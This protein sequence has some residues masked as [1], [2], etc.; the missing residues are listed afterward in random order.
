MLDT[1]MIEVTEISE[2]PTPACDNRDTRRV[3]SRQLLPVVSHRRV[4]LFVVT[5]HSPVIEEIDVDGESQHMARVLDSLPLSRIHRTRL[6]ASPEFSPLNIQVMEFF[7]ELAYESDEK[8]L[9]SLKGTH[10]AC[11]C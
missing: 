6:G 3:M 10:I 4:V 8:A 5:E 7:K 1:K 9:F 11:R 2:V